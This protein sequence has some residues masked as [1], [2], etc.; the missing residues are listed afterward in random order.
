MNTRESS[1]GHYFVSSLSHQ[2]DGSDVI[3]HDG[4]LFDFVD[5][6]IRKILDEYPNH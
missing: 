3:D 1:Q 6:P 4:N 2:N 5:G